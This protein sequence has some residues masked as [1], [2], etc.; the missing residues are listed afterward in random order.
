[1][2]EIRQGRAWPLGGPVASAVRLATKA[3]LDEVCESAA[4]ACGD[5]LLHSLPH[6]PRVPARRCC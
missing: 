2:Q 4:S 1:L 5:R 6:T 3:M